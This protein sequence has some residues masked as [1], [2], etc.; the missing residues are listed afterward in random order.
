M[1]SQEVSVSKT[2]DESVHGW[3]A[4]TMHSSKSKAFTFTKNAGPQFNPL[5]DAK[6]MFIFQ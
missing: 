1:K 2:S 6:A 3:K 5:P 4:V